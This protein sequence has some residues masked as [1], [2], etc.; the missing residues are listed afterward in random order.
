MHTIGTLTSGACW[1]WCWAASER[2]SEFSVGFLVHLAPLG[3]PLRVLAGLQP[4]RLE[5]LQSTT[6]R[7]SALHF[8][9]SS[10]LHYCL[11]PLAK[12]RC[13]RG[14]ES[15]AKKMLLVRC[16]GLFLVSWVALARANELVR[17]DGGE[18]HPFD[19][20]LVMCV[21]VSAGFVRWKGPGAA[22]SWA[23]RARARASWSRSSRLYIR[24]IQAYAVTN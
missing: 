20:C 21:C 16:R 3:A 11:W 13:L 2:A 9:H 10:H 22:R 17:H 4:I 7:I 1:R 24:C 5:E 18:N 19:A 8:L 6:Q 14:R 23:G 15:L 12:A